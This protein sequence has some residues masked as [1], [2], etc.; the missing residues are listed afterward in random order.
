ICLIYNT[1]HRRCVRAS[2][3]LRVP[4]RCNHRLAVFQNSNVKDMSF[5]FLPSPLCYLRLRGVFVIFNYVVFGLLN[6]NNLFLSHRHHLPFFLR[7]LAASSWNLS[8]PY[9]LRPIQA[10]SAFGSSTPFAA[11]DFTRRSK[12]SPEPKGGFFLGA[13]TIIPF[14]VDYKTK[15]QESPL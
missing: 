14:R 3:S 11:N 9:F 6:T 4:Y 2:L 7:P 5:H 13:I 10:A 8:L 1:P 12:R 15:F